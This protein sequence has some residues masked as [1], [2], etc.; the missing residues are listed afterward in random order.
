[1]DSLLE[2]IDSM[3]L[4]QKNYT[5]DNLYFGYDYKQDLEKTALERERIFRLRNI[6]EETVESDEENFFDK[7]PIEEEKPSTQ[8]VEDV[9]KPKKE[10]KR[11]L[12]VEEIDDLDQEQAEFPEELPAG[13]GMMKFA[14]ART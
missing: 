6:R 14:G 7:A 13:F 3:R 4:L 2:T 9:L 11:K 12:P 8:I 10:K 1:M 5:R